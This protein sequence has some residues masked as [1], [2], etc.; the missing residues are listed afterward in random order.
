MQT[1]PTRQE[2]EPLDPSIA[3]VGRRRILNYPINREPTTAT[4]Y[5][6]HSEDRKAQMTAP[7]SSCC[8]ANTAPAR[9]PASPALH[10]VMVEPEIPGNSGNVGRTCLATGAK[11]HL[12]EP[13][14]FNIDDRAVR[15][16]GLDY[17]KYVD[18][19]VWPSW[20]KFEENLEELGTAWFFSAEADRTVWDADLKGDTVLVFGCETC[21]LSQPMRSQYQ[22]R[23]L[24]IPIVS[25]HVRSLN[26]ATAAAI[27]IYE[28]QRQRRG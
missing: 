12:I 5:L 16:A 20:N 26:V 23:L 6:A 24:Q 19:E 21:G 8:K 4:H 15:R 1:Q 25:P 27:A 9:P 13:L 7:A 18:L 17:W 22:D 14:G 3:L 28:A 10:V 11:L 2:Q